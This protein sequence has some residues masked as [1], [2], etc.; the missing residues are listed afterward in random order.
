M[1]WIFEGPKVGI[2]KPPS[3]PHSA[4][5]HVNFGCSLLLHYMGRTPV[6]PHHQPTPPHISA[7]P[8]QI[9]SLPFSFTTTNC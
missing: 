9:S 3:L 8:S 1:K 7:S 4:D 5:H 6:R 2:S